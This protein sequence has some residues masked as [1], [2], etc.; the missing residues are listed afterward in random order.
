MFMDELEHEERKVLGLRKHPMHAR[1]ELLDVRKA[2]SE[3]ET[4]PLKEHPDYMIR[5]TPEPRNE[6]TLGKRRR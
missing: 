3:R 4:L 5:E 2:E 6:T 1:G